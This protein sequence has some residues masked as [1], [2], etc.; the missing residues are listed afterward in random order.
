MACARK[1]G[2]GYEIKVS[3]GYGVDG[4]KIEKYKRWYPEPNMTAKQI[5]KELERQKILF[6]DEVKYG[7]VHSNGI[8][9]CNFAAEWMQTY[10]EP[11]SAPKTISRYHDFLRRI[12]PVIGHLKIQDITPLHLNALY[13]GLSKEGVSKRRRKDENGNYTDNGQLAPKTIL[14]HHRLISKIL[15]TAVKWQLLETNVAE[16]ADPP[17]LQAREMYFLNET[18]AKRLLS[19]L[20]NEPI[21]YRTMISILLFTGI[22]RGELCGLEWKDIDFDNRVMHII[23]TSQFIN[24][25]FLTKEPKTKSGRRELTLSYGACEILTQYKLW[26]NEQRAKLGDRWVDND[27]LFTQ[28]DGKPIH[29]DTVTDWFAKFIKNNDLPKITL[30]SLRHTNA[31]LMIAEGTDIRTV[32]SRLGHAQTSTTLNIYTHAL[33]SRD[34]VAADNLDRILGTINA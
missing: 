8:K 10:A 4:K 14:E 24:G 1:R 9:F 5:E 34:A 29:P 17:K 26:Q 21:Q 18:E 12:N 30:H 19:L 23:R 15:S 13:K 3:C 20:Q 28:Y 11:K 7:K 25:G 22:R 27:R 16:R 32:S 6:E 2:R 31:T 33:K